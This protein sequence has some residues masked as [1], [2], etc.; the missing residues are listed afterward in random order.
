MG[1]SKATSVLSLHSQEM[2]RILLLEGGRHSV[3]S[4]AFD[5]ESLVVF[6]VTSQG[7]RLEH[8]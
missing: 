6:V 4:Q 7:S 8:G 3:L 1:R 5:I 2:N